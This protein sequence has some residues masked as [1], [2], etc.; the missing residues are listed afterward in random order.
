M[1]KK[2]KTQISELFVN[3]LVRE[4]QKF[5]H[6][7]YADEMLRVGVT[8]RQLPRAAFEFA[9][10]SLPSEFYR[11]TAEEQKEVEKRLRKYYKGAF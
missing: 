3:T 10:D 8:E 4:G 2:N 6:P 11:L 1:R 5:S 7:E 9:M